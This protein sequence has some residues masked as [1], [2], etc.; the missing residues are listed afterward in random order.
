MAAPAPSSA[1]L[2]PPALCRELAQQLAADLTARRWWLLLPERLCADLLPSAPAHTT[3]A[4]AQGDFHP[5][6]TFW[7]ALPDTARLQFQEDSQLSGQGLRLPTLLP[8]ETLR[9]W[10]ALRLP[11]QNLPDAGLLL[12]LAAPADPATLQA[13]A[14]SRT[15]ALLRLALEHA[16][17]SQAVVLHRHNVELLHTLALRLASAADLQQTLDFL[18]EA[19][20]DLSEA[21][22]AYLLT[23]PPEGSPG[24]AFSL[25]ASRTRLDQPVPGYADFLA[26]LVQIL[27]Q[28]PWPLF[29]DALP[30]HPLRHQ[31]G[32][33][34]SGF[35]SLAAL[36]IT[37]EVQQLGFLVIVYLQPHTFRAEE[38]YLLT[39]LTEQAGAAIENA[40]LRHSLRLRQAEAALLL[41]LSAAEQQATD[42]GD[43]L[44]Q[45]SALLQEYFAAEAEITLT[46]GNLPLPTAVFRTPP[47]EEGVPFTGP[48][49]AE[50]AASLLQKPLQAGGQTLG[51]MR[52]FSARPNAFSAP[53][54]QLL[55]LAAAHAAAAI[56]SARRLTELN[57]ELR[58]LQEEAASRAAIAETVAHE[59]HSP[60]TF[61]CSYLD[62]L[63][64][65]ELGA[66]TPDQLKSLH[67]LQEKT[68]HLERLV[69]DLMLLESQ[70]NAFLQP[71]QVNLAELASNCL[72]LITPAARLKGMSLELRI[73]PNFPTIEADPDRLMQALD[74]LLSNALKYGQGGGRIVVTLLADP[75]SVTLTVFNQGEA[76]SPADY[77][78][79]FQPYYRGLSQQRGLGLGLAIV[80]RVAEAH[81]GQAWM[82]SEPGVGNTFYL[83]LPYFP[84]PAAPP[85]APSALSSQ[86]TP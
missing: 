14:Q 44:G 20:L 51:Q 45:L 36:P 39:M 84:Q 67:I 34:L 3:L 40:R 70:S 31:L 27:L 11:L 43:L 83:S 58:Q 1:P 42:L 26:A 29:I 82:D 52:L 49:S 32:G 57:A 5:I 24:D 6:Q 19:A 12:E 35:A 22:V 86:E 4:I 30:S 16:S 62:L 75:V 64:A 55:E 17:Q 66:I 63:A 41:R 79:L 50:N 72:E 56:L 68:R 71:R 46:D 9:D 65:G 15:A 38:R 80:R 18:A 85:S 60:L 81:G 33:A 7:Q 23:H 2:D 8:G 74:N 61:L 69:D 25:Q 54:E 78:R 53:D 10:A 13:A 37:H 21:D 47:P 28:R 48:L 76:V 77:E 59:L 73:P